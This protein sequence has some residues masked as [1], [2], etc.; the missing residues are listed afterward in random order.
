MTYA[1]LPQVRIHGWH[2][3]QRSTLL[4]ACVALA[5]SHTPI[6]VQVVSNICTAQ[7]ASLPDISS[8][9]I[10]QNV[11]V[12][13]QQAPIAADDNVW[14]AQSWVAANSAFNPSDPNSVTIIHDGNVSG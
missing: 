12:N 11:T 2:Y 3:V 6:A 7:A 14:L 1:E 13:V 4:P 8:L 10:L 9:L 5:H